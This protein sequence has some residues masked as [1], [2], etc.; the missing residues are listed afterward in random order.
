[1]PRLRRIHESGSG[2]SLNFKGEKI[3]IESTKTEKLLPQ[4]L[5][6]NKICS[7]GAHRSFSQR[8]KKYN[9]RRDI[10]QMTHEKVI[11]TIR[12]VNAVILEGKSLFLSIVEKSSNAQYFDFY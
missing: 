5:I 10:R 12:V 7:K 9:R 4:N 1:M 3:S 8:C 2:R 11:S 6:K